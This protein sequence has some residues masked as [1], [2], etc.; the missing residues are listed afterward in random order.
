MCIP[1][2][3]IASTLA[4]CSLVSAV[5]TCTKNGSPD[6]EAQ[7]SF[8]KREK[9]LNS[10]IIRNYESKENDPDGKPQPPAANIPEQKPASDRR[11]L[12]NASVP[13]HELLD[14]TKLGRLSDPRRLIQE[15]T[16]G[17]DFEQ[18][19]AVVAKPE[20][21]MPEK[22]EIRSAIYEGLEKKR[23]T[24]QEELQSVFAEM[25]EIK[26]DGGGKGGGKGG[27]GGNKSLKYKENAKSLND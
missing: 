11:D 25:A 17:T 18:P 3:V 27:D 26:F 9:E 4:L 10:L 16:E 24:L 6:R 7:R 12:K 14:P 8:T 19:F 1:V 23:G 2:A 5:C 21:E 15:A 22:G 13:P 20:F